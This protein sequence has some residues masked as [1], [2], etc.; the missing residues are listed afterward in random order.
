[1]LPHEM[2]FLAQYQLQTKL[3]KSLSLFQLYL[4][5]IDSIND[6]FKIVNIASMQ[7]QNVVTPA[8]NYTV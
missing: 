4:V 3:M 8:C 5:F 1:M 7:L 2:L 6:I